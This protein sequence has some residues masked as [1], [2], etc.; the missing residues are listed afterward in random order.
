MMTHP[1]RAARAR[2]PRA[3]ASLLAGSSAGSSTDLSTGFTRL[4]HMLGCAM[5]CLLAG[6]TSVPKDQFY[7]LAA[8]GSQDSASKTQMQWVLGGL[9]LPQLVDRPQLVVRRNAQQVQILEQQRWAEPLKLDMGRALAG[10]LQEKGIQLHPRSE[11][12]ARDGRS[13]LWIDVL[14][15]ESSPGRE[16]VLEV[17]WQLRSSSGALLF[18]QRGLW[19]EPVAGADY[20]AL[21]AAH[22]RALQQCAAAIAQGAPASGPNPAA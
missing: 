21:I 2:L 13:Q 15:F 11:F 22:Q 8:P 5:L 3:S 1:N 4:G 10:Y 6:C 16:V 12:A 9:N 19:R 17:T 14:Q 18:S 7:T 20:P